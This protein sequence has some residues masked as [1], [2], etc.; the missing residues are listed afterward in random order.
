MGPEILKQVQH[1]LLVQDD[2]LFTIYSSK[3]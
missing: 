1:K 2:I 3:D